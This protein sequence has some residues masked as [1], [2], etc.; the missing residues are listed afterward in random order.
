[1]P[2]QNLVQGP[3]GIIPRAWRP[4]PSYPSSPRSCERGGDAS[5]ETIAA[6]PGEPLHHEEGPQRT[7]LSCQVEGLQITARGDI[8]A[9]PDQRLDRFRRSF[10]SFDS[11]RQPVFLETSG[12]TGDKNRQIDEPS[13]RD[14]Q[15][16]LGV[17]W[18]PGGRAAPACH[19]KQ[20]AKA[21]SSLLFEKLICIGLL[22]LQLPLSPVRSGSE[23]PPRELPVSYSARQARARSLQRSIASKSDFASGDRLESGRISRICCGVWP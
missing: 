12:G 4:R 6:K 13:H 15:P 20:A 3:V 10:G 11:H 5:G 7:S 18:L 23:R 19:G 9:S 14:R 16:H 1:M 21:T 2:P 8:H 17:L 22:A